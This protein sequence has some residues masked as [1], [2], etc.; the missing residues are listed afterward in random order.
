[1]K[2]A[3]TIFWAAN[4]SVVLCAWSQ[5][6]Q[7]VREQD[8]A[9]RAQA[10][11]QSQLEQ[12][13]KDQQESAIKIQKLEEKKA[14]CTAQ[15]LKLE[16]LL[17]NL[18]AAIEVSTT[19]EFKAKWQKEL[20]ERQEDRDKFAAL[21]AGIEA[22]IQQN[23]I[24]HEEARAK[25]Q[26]LALLEAEIDANAQDLAKIRAT[27]Q[28]ANDLSQ[29]LD[30]FAGNQNQTE[31][32]KAEAIENLAALGD[33]VLSALHHFNPS[34]RSQASAAAVAAMSQLRLLNRD[35]DELQKYYRLLLEKEKALKAAGGAIV[36]G[37]LDDI[38][39]V[40]RA[41]SRLDDVQ[42]LREARA[43]REKIRKLQLAKKINKGKNFLKYVRAAFKLSW[44][45]LAL[46]LFGVEDYLIDLAIEKVE[47]WSEE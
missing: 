40:R 42:D 43:L 46:T 38:H 27:I 28:A 35:L 33:R 25:E 29:T 39:D 7:T 8:F 22:Q 37:K 11:L 2:K 18:G 6:R 20:R 4:V 17:R 3:S 24:Q 45:G 14:Q 30:A 21:L 9:E 32:E 44:F 16:T 47:A 12:S 15:I 34:N 1:M 19:P 31:E 36:L 23:R 5:T 10:L 26:Q 41:M 13:R